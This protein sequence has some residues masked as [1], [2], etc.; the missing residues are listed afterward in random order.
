[1]GQAGSETAPI[2]PLTPGDVRQIRLPWMS[3]FSP[4]RMAAHIEANPDLSLWVPETGEYVV[5]ER[6]RNRDEIVRIVE[7]TTRK[8]QARLVAALME[9]AK[10]RGHSLIL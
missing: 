9:R 6:W 1:M 8:G 5:G 3:R 4:E 7:A 2:E 10:E